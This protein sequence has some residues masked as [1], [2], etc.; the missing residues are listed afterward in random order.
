MWCKHKYVREF[1]LLFISC[2]CFKQFEFVKKKHFLVLHIGFKSHSS[3]ALLQLI[4]IASRERI[5]M[6]ELWD[7]GA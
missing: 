2:F 3:Y 7:P 4:E 1:N 6:L 5:R